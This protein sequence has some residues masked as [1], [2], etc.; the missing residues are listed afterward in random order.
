MRAIVPQG[1]MAERT[2]GG[3]L[4][5]KICGSGHVVRIPLGKSEAP[6]KERV[7]PPC[8]FAGLGI[9]TLPPPELAS[10]DAPARANSLFAESEL[11]ALRIADPLPHPPARGPPLTA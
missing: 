1:Y 5:V 6:D 10:L 4:T 7:Q 8:A 2:G 3:A 9:A 11:A